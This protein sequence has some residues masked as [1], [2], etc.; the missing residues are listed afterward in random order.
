MPGHVVAL[1]AEAWCKSLEFSLHHKVNSH[2]GPKELSQGV[3][4]TRSTEIIVF[5]GSF[6]QGIQ[7]FIYLF[8]W[9]AIILES[10]ILFGEIIYEIGKSF[11]SL[12]IPK[13]RK[14]VTGKVVLI[15]GAAHG[16]GRQLAIR[17]AR[18]GAILVLWDIDKEKLDALV[19]QLQS[20]GATVIASRVDVSDFTA[21]ATAA[22]TVRS[23]VGHVDILVNNAATL[24]VQSFFDTSAAEI[25]RTISSNTLS[26]FW[27]IKCF[28]PDMVHN[29]SGHIVA[30]ASNLAIF[31][32]S[33]FADYA[34]SKFA[35]NGLMQSLESELHEM[36]KDKIFF[37]T[38]CPAAIDTG[39]CRVIDTRFP[40]LFPILQPST[41][42]KMIIDAIL[43]NEPFVVFPTG[44][45]YLYALLRILPH[46]VTHLMA[47][48][49]GNTT[50]IK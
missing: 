46:R 6:D 12:F 39:L 2:I 11:C 21:V 22:E 5:H 24:R 40:R 44:Y 45:R 19:N 49:L 35:V 50:E 9:L 10:N 42:A 48:F 20:V 38:V 17:F 32:K 16:L 1:N 18:L 7:M 15:T 33:H 41:A 31:G 13:T 4:S 29:N 43:T 36:R 47:D 28:L 23:R 30:I 3:Q 27:T 8:N 26:H 34:A 14:S 37:T 25:E